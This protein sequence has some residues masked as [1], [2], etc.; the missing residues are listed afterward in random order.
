MTPLPPRS[1]FRS[2][3]AAAVAV[4][5][6]A[7]AAPAAAQAC[8]AGGALVTPVRLAP[9]EDAAVGVLA[10]ARLLLG[11]FDA[12]GRYTS[13]AGIGEQDFEQDVA[14]TFRVTHRAQAGLVV[15]FFETRRSLSGASGVGGGLGDVSVDA[16]YD[17]VTAAET[18]YWPGIA[19]LASVVL[20][21]GTAVADANALATNVTGAGTTDVSIGADLES[22]SG[23]IYAAL[24]AWLTVRFP[25]GTTQVAETLAPQWTVLAVG[26]YVFENESALAVFVSWLDE[27]DGTV[28]GARD[29]GTGLRLTTAGAAGVLPLSDAWRLQ[30]TVSGDLPWSSFGQNEPTG[31]GA[32]ATLVRVWK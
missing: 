4:A 27:G 30:V 5:I 26:G 6:S 16:R 15:P 17:F 22:A 25:H 28:A 10:R 20:P 29:P 31:I 18:L 19:L 7:R 21:T 1:T 3:W 12:G 8:C 2:G 23:H 9:F 11:S 13:T 24:N 14:A 32:S